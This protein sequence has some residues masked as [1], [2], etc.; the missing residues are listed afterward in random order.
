MSTIFYEG[1]EVEWVGGGGIKAE[2]HIVS[3]GSTH[4][5]VKWASGPD[6]LDITFVDLYDLEPV[7]AKKV[8]EDPMHMVAVRRA[9]DREAV[10]GVLNFL[11]SNNYL[12]TWQD[13]AKD[14]LAYV[15]SR[16]RTDASMDLVEEQL[17]V[18]EREQVVKAGALA[19]L[20]DA[21]SES[22]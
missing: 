20:R 3:L 19:L 10:T 13:I 21:F 12:D 4:A 8:E 18:P 6:A 7:T 2:G 15:E 14:V 16:I 22:E 5:H 9:F 1:A 11:A 17:S